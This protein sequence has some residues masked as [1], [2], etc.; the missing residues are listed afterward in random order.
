M[1]QMKKPC[2]V[3]RVFVVFRLC[4]ANNLEIDSEFEKVYILRISGEKQRIILEKWQDFKKYCHTKF[5]DLIYR[6]L[7]VDRSH[8][9]IHSAKL[10]AEKI[11][12]EPYVSY[13]AKVQQHTDKGIVIREMDKKRSYSNAEIAYQFMVATGVFQS[14]D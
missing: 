9:F 4:K 10:F 7:N 11:I 6:N 5:T 12:R 13:V 3:E 2:Y 1:Q 8:E 14:V